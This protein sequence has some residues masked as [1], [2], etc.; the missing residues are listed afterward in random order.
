[1]RGRRDSAAPAF[2]GAAKGDKAGGLVFNHKADADKF[3]IIEFISG[4][5]GN[6]PGAEAINAAA[7]VFVGAAKAPESLAAA[8]ECRSA[9]R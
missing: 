3:N 9:A 8:Y 5:E 7:P 6:I 1:M 2:V 4:A